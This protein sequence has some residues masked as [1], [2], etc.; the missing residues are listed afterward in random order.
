MSPIT[1]AENWSR[2]RILDAYLTPL[3]VKNISK[4][5]LTARGFHRI[6]WIIPRTSLS[7]SRPRG[8][9]ASSWEPPSI[10]PTSRDSLSHAASAQSSA[11][12]PLSLSPPNVS[13]DVVCL[14]RVRSLSFASAPGARPDFLLASMNYFDNFLP[15]FV[16]LDWQ[17]IDSVIR[18]RVRLTTRSAKRD[19]WTVRKETR[20]GDII[21]EIHRLRIVFFKNQESSSFASRMRGILQ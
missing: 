19:V 20:H 14:S 12:P 6:I 9:A 10:H 5:Y 2:R 17:N 13:P 18:A 11:A 16:I 4:L 1:V 15:G 7:S 3:W 8:T 21:D